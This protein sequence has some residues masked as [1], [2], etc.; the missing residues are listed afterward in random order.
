MVIEL[1]LGHIEMTIPDKTTSSL[2]RYCLTDVSDKQV[3][4]QGRP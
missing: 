4:Q 1:C 2:Q 3:Q